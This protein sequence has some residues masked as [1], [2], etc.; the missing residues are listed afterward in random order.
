MLGACSYK[1]GD[2]GYDLSQFKESGGGNSLSEELRA[3]LKSNPESIREITNQLD[4][5]EL[6]FVIVGDTISDKNESFRSM[7]TDIAGLDPAPSF[8]VHLGDRVVSPV[9]EHYGSYFETISRLP[10]PILH[11]DGNHDI[12]EEGERISRAFFGDKDFFFDLRDLRFIFMS[13]VDPDGSFGFSRRQL[14]WLENVLDTPYPSRKLFFSHVPPKAPFKEITPGIAS[15]FTPQLENEGEFLDLLSRHNV[16]LAAFGHRHVHASLVYKGVLMVITG[17]GGQRNYF[18]PAVDVPLFTKKRHY[19]L[20]DIS[21]TGESR[22]LEGVLSCLGKGNNPLFVSSFY[23]GVT[24][25]AGGETP[26]ELLT[27]FA[28]GGIPV[29][30]DGLFWRTPP[31]SRTP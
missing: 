19:S 30:P 10:C 29:R 23:Q 20:V 7:L 4:G 2:N 5:E 21:S 12:R 17:G 11:V 24:W 14:G 31:M 16:V 26:V 9:V 25:P 15:W 1:V 8:I 22:L 27:Y 28:A 6:R 13:D 3:I 18:E